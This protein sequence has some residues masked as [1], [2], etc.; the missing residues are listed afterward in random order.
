MTRFL[1]CY[2]PLQ[3]N[4]APFEFSSNTYKELNHT[5]QGGQ[6]STKEVRRRL[7]EKEKE[8]QVNQHGRIHMFPG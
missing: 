1:R 7:I 4:L 5:V 8:V 6:V 2:H 3:K